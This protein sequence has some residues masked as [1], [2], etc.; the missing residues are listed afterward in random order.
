MNE[1]RVWNKK[2]KNYEN[3]CSF[4]I[5]QDGD[6][7]IIDPTG[8]ELCIK[9]DYIIERST[10]KK[11][12]RNKKIFKNDILLVICDGIRSVH[13]IIWGGKDYPAYCLYPGL[14]VDCNDFSQI[15]HAGGYKTRVIGNIHDNPELLGGK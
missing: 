6:L 9:D 5:D 1:F 13:K 15:E 8:Y 10:G 11:D 12:S 2:Y 14:D 3:L 7:L 4:A